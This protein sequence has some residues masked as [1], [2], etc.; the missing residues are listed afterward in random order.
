MGK[1]DPRR[2]WPSS[3]CRHMSEKKAASAAAMSRPGHKSC[4]ARG[5]CR[6]SAWPAGLAALIAATMVRPAAGGARW[7]RSGRPRGSHRCIEG[8]CMVSSPPASL[9]PAPHRDTSGSCM[10]LVSNTWHSEPLATSM[11]GRVS[12]A[13]PSRC[14]PVWLS[15]PVTLPAMAPVGSSGVSPY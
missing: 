3:A 9:R 5:V 10:A 4:S 12:W 7:S 1:N 6:S 15:C 8:A 13:R 11:V 14:C 2:V